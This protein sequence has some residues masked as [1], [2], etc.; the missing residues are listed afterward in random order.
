MLQLGN[1]QQIHVSYIPQ[2]KEAHAVPECN[3]YLYV[4]MCV[5]VCMC[6]YVCEIIHN[7]YCTCQRWPVFPTLLWQ[8]TAMNKFTNQLGRHHMPT[9]VSSGLQ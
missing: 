5:H 8:H 3:Y 4:R 1:I 9:Q 7:T 6:A 2:A